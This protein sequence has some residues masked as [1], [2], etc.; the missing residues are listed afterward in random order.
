MVVVVVQTAATNYY[1]Y[2]TFLSL[3]INRRTN[4]N[5]PLPTHFNLPE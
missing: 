5:L 4:R 1:Y 2:S 3:Y